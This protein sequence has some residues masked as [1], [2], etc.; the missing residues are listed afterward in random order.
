MLRPHLAARRDE[1]GDEAG[2]GDRRE[3]ERRRGGHDASAL[4]TPGLDDHVRASRQADHLPIGSCD[5]VRSPA[6]RRIRATARQQHARAVDVRRTARPGPSCAPPPAAWV[7]PSRSCRSATSATFSECRASATERRSSS[8]MRR[9]RTA[10]RRRSRR[11][12]R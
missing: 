7:L 11:S 10:A 3:R 9:R 6:R 12:R 1:A 5:L 4:P 8:V 2:R